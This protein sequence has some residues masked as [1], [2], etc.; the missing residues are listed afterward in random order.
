MT[1]AITRPMAAPMG[2]E[3]DSAPTPASRSTR[4][5]SSVGYDTE[6]SLAQAKR[7]RRVIIRGSVRVETAAVWAPPAA[8]RVAVRRGGDGTPHDP[9]LEAA[10]LHRS[11]ARLPRQRR[12]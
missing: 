12:W 8:A 7:G 5:I 9:L 4:R 1:M 11:G 10:D 2:T 3:K 6:E